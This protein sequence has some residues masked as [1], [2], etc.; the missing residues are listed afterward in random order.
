M[1]DASIP[2]TA[3]EWD[4]WGN[5]QEEKYTAYMHSYSPVDNIKDQ[6]YPNM[7]ITSG[8]HTQPVAP[9]RSV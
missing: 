5:P 8:Q 3:V 1:S 9:A 7:L 2:L 6:L 4:E